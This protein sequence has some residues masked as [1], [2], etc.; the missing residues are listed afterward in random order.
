MKNLAETSANLAVDLAGQSGVRQNITPDQQ[1]ALV[2]EALGS[3][4]FDKS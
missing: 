4:V 3:L 1:A 2:R